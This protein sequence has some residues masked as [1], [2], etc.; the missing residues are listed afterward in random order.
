MTRIRVVLATAVM[1]MAASCGP[2]ASS[3]PG[4][5]PATGPVTQ[6][7]VAEPAAP[8]LDQILAASDLPPPLPEPLPGDALGVTHCSALRD[9]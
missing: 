1:M 6:E 5:T 7:P 8:P 3:S 4:P 9:R 2:K